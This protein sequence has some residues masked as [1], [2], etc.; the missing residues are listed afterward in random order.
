MDEEKKNQELSDEELDNVNGG[1]GFFGRIFRRNRH[2]AAAVPYIIVKP[3]DIAPEIPEDWIKWE[4][5]KCSYAV[6]TP[7]EITDAP[8]CPDHKTRCLKVSTSITF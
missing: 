4:C 3:G 6:Y 7:P 8:L 2:I 5:P 1:F